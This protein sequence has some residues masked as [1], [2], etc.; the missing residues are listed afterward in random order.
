MMIEIRFHGRGGQGVVTCAEL[1]A[2]AVIMEGR[3]A[4]AKPSFGSERRGAPVQA[5]CRISDSPI[6][7]RSDI[8]NPDG[9]VVLDPL[10]IA[11]KDVLSGLKEGG[12]IVV[13][14]ARKV[15]E[16]LS[17]VKFRAKYG[18]VNAT[19]IAVEKIKVPIA[20]TAMLGA[21]NKVYPIVKVETM[22]E[23]FKERFG[24]KWEGNFSAFLESYEKTEVVDGK[25]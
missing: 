17:K 13:N 20:N 6:V 11:S 7:N 3:Y 9:I 5:F 23:V 22:K 21:L 4:Q 10:L 24:D 19:A 25:I 18:I 12:F 8:Y 2:S 15:E 14:T 1:L 16:I